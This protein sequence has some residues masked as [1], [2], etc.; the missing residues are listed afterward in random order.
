M[1]N[2][3]EL[4]N[5]LQAVKTLQSLKSKLE[6][7]DTGIGTANTRV[8]VILESA[9]ELMQQ[10]GTGDAF[11]WTSDQLVDFISGL[12]TLITDHLNSLRLENNDVN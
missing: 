12:K 3:T 4:G 5:T 8:D 11:F 6:L 9:I 10:E 1:D 2:T 7:F